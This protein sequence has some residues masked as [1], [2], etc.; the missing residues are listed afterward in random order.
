MI[1]PLVAKEGAAADAANFREDVTVSGSI[2]ASDIA[3]VKSRSG[4]G[5]P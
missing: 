3:L 2:N 1:E 5:V 4:F